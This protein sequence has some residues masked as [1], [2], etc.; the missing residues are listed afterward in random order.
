MSTVFLAL[1]GYA[2]AA[3]TL[4]NPVTVA[5]E[6][7]Q[8][9]S[10]PGVKAHP[11]ASSV[12][13]KWLSDLL[14]AAK[15][16]QVIVKNNAAL[17][18]DVVIQTESGELDAGAMMVRAG[19]AA[20]D[21][22]QYSGLQDEAEAEQIGLWSGCEG[23]MGYWERREKFTGFPK[24]I[25]FGLAMNESKHKG[26]PW[27]WTINVRGQGW[28]FKDRMSAYKAAQYLLDNGIT[29]FDVGTHQ[30]NWKWH[31]KRF[32]SLWDAF[33]PEVNY[34]VAH[35]IYREEFK[36]TGDAG[37]AIMRYHSR[38]P[39]KGAHYLA[40]FMQQLNSKK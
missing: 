14:A 40:G 3:A 21:A 35:Q 34:R 28:F 36:A 22:K 33:Q 12:A 18:G 2:S 7:G 15:A 32:T 16:S 30:V 17:P 23:R 26:K 13:G 4:V 38:D 31:Q 29:S 1:S 10:L 25:A 20:G 39:T 9:L 6:S 5:T 11:C 19:L 8:Q 24:E 27:P 37:K